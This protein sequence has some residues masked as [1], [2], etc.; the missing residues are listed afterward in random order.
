MQQ[1]IVVTG[2]PGTGKSTVIR[3][4]EKRNYACMHEISRQLTLDAR[5]DGV[6]QLF[7]EDPLLFSSKLLI[8]RTKQFNTANNL[9]NNMVFFDRAYALHCA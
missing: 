3:E 7:I 5:K 8:E 4:L 1:K 9:G 6:E 2:G